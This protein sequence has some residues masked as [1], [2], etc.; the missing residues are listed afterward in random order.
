MIWHL[1]VPSQ[2]YTEG[3]VKKVERV[4]GEDPIG[5]GAKGMGST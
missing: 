3:G 1:V 5:Q 2:K 4:S